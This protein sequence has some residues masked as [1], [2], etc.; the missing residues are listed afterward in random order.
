MVHMF[1]M[2]PMLAGPEQNRV[3]KRAGSE[4]EREKSNHPVRLESQMCKQPMIT[5]GDRKADGKKHHK[6]KDDLESIN[7]KKPEISRDRGKREK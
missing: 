6:E 1:V 4:N 5:K 3:F 7:P 2:T